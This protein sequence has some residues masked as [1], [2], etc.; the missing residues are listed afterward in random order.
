[1]TRLLL[2]VVLVATGVVLLLRAFDGGGPLFYFLAAVFI[3]MGIA[4]LQQGG[5]KPPD[6]GD[7]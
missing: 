1:M 7:R 4:A 3:G 6:D 5:R 2:P